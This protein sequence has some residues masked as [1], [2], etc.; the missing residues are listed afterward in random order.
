MAST[1][2]M[3]QNAPSSPAQRRRGT[4]RTA[5]WLSHW[6]GPCEMTRQPQ[7]GRSPRHAAGTLRATR[8][9]RIPGVIRTRPGGSTRRWLAELRV[10]APERSRPAAMA[11]PAAGRIATNPCRLPA[12]WHPGL[13]AAGSAHH[14]ARHFRF[15]SP[16]Q[17]RAGRD[18]CYPSPSKR[19]PPWPA[20][21]LPSRLAFRCICRG[22]ARVL[23]RSAAWPLPP[24]DLARH[25]S[26][27]YMSASRG[28]RSPP[29]LLIRATSTGAQDGHGRIPSHVISQRVHHVCGT[30]PAALTWQAGSVAVGGGRT[31]PAR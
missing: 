14:A 27:R 18:R 23:L 30:W 31:G 17:A 8:R 2:C 4:G 20:Q 28:R 9:C 6:P 12:R 24:A 15:E 7:R 5:R 25:G 29:L 11:Q 13:P 22:A 21:L 1:T 16:R 19:R 26:S 10:M 3:P